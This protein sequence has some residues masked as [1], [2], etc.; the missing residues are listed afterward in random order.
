[1]YSQDELIAV[2]T[3]VRRR[4]LAAILPA[5]ALFGI[6][7][8][9]FLFGQMNRSDKLWMLTV[10]LT[11]LGG[12]WFLF[13][14]GVCVK[15]LMIYREHIRYMLEGRKRETTG[16]LKA[17]SQDISD[18]DGLECHAM[19][20][21]VGE[22]DGPEDDRLFYFDAHKTFPQIPLGTRITVCSN[23]KMVASI[24]MA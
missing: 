18:R 17:F 15:P 16:V 5:V 11:I 14:Y 1:M 20:L 8:A 3:M 12:S 21:N 24:Q 19:L 13:L 10:A 23:D 6:A 22:K 7:L 4:R 2:Q 9:V